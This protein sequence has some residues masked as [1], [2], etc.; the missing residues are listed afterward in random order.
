MLVETICHFGYYLCGK[1]FVACTDYKP[2]CSLL[3]SDRLNG[4]L[5]RLGMKL[6]HWLTDVQYLPGL[7]NG[8]ADVLSREERRFS[9]TV[10][11]DGLQSGAGGCGGAP[12]TDEER[13]HARGQEG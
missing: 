13:E 4:R 7:E 8:L 9:E 3:N 6:Q 12:S 5:R 1:Q 11:A 2:L 10:A